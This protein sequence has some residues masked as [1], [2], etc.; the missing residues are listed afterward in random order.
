MSQTLRPMEKQID[1]PQR[2]AHQ[3]LPK[4]FA[5][6]QWTDIQP[7]YE[8]LLARELTSLGALKQWFLDR[9]ELEGALSED[10]C[11]ALSSAAF[12]RHPRNSPHSSSF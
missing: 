1:I 4:I 6:T 12:P 8:Q 2:K 10:L 9:S 11:P 7:F 5:V 3:F